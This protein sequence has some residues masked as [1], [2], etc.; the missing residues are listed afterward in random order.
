MNHSTTPARTI[1]RQPRRLP[2]SSSIFD[3]AP[4]RC[5]PLSYSVLVGP[6]YSADPPSAS[7]IAPSPQPPAKGPSNRV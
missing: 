5:S 1:P 4:L 3:M 2:I 6:F 7:P